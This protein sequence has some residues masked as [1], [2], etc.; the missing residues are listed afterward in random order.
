[1]EVDAAAAGVVAG[2]GAGAAAG[3]A[4]AGPAAHLGLTGLISERV[5]QV[6]PAAAQAPAGAEFVLYWM[7]SAVRGHENPALDV[8]R[9]G[10]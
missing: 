7:C 10:G 8:A 5:R 1:M 2:A 4:A 9:W 6:V 3:P